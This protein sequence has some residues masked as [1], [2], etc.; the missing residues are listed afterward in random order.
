MFLKRVSAILR[1]Y[2]RNIFSSKKSSSYNELDIVAEKLDV[3]TDYI[4]RKIAADVCEAV[5]NAGV[6]AY[7]KILKNN[8]ARMSM[9]TDGKVNRAVR[10]PC[11]D[12][13]TFFRAGAAGDQRDLYTAGSKQCGERVVMLCSQNFR[14]CHQGGL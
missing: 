13:A 10:E 1:K 12:R 6:L 2:F 11:E 14:R 3:I 9:C 4:G 8:I 5:D 7:V